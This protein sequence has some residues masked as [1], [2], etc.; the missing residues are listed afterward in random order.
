MAIAAKDAMSIILVTV[1]VDIQLPNPKGEQIVY[2][3]VSYMS[4]SWNDTFM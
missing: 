1:F 4:H 2:L 3:Q